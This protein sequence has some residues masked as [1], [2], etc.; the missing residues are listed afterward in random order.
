[1]QCCGC[2]PKFRL[3]SI[4]SGVVDFFFAK[5]RALQA[6]LTFF[7]KPFCCYPRSSTESRITVMI[8]R[9]RTL[10]DRLTRIIVLYRSALERNVSVT[11][12]NVKRPKLKW[13]VQIVPRRGP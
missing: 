7:G 10:C 9:H 13:V 3:R 8:R 5:G 4:R 2:K 11:C 6:A 12:S 1:V